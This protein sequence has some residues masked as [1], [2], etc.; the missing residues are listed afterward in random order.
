MATKRSGSRQD[1]SIV[2]GGQS[3]LAVTKWEKAIK[4]C[5]DTV[6]D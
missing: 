3:Y 5:G 1:V 2:E 4:S 6:M